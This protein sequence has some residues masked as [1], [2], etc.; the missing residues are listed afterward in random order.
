MKKTNQTNDYNN[1]VLLSLF[2][3]FFTIPHTLEDFATG[4]PQE[5]GVPAS[6]LSFVISVVLLVQGLGLYYLGQKNKKG[7]YIHVGLGLFWPVASG[8]AQLPA[9]LSGETY[10]S[11]ISSKLYVF[12]MI[13]VGLLMLVAS[14]KFLKS[15]GN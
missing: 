10:R 1:V 2:L 7:L 4:A 9:I 6:V 8:I 3:F 15:Q 14:I 13:I 12:G 5:A 11:G